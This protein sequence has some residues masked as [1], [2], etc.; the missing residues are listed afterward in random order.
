MNLLS[1]DDYQRAAEKGINQF[2][3]EARV[4]E[5]GWSVEDAIRLPY[6]TR[7]GLSGD[8]W[9]QYQETATKNGISRETFVSRVRDKRTSFYNNPLKAATTPIKGGSRN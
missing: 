6:R 4:Y 7:R 1:N 5:H 3:L 8:M 2:T 9:L